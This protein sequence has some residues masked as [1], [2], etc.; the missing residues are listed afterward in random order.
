MSDP[1]EL[2]PVLL[3]LVL[4]V[5]L[6]MYV[7]LDGFDLGIGILFPCFRDASAR[8]QMMNS[9]APFWDGNET[10]L[11]LGGVTLWAAFPKAFAIIL[12]AMYLPVL[13]LL[14]ALIFRGVAFEFRWVAKG[15]QR[16]WD[17]A[18]AAGSTLAAFAQGVILGGLLQEI[19]VRDGQFAGGPFD[20]LSPF[21]LMCGLGLLNG[22]ALL[23][24]A[25]LMMKTDGALAARVRK[26]APALLA[27]LLGFIVLVSI[28]TP[29]QIPRVAQRWF[30]L[31]NL[32]FL[33]PV[34]LATALSA[35]LCWRAIRQD[36][37]VLAF[38]AAVGLFLLAMGALVLS[39]MPYVV[40]PA[41]TVWQAA[42]HPSSQLFY[43]VGASILL[44]LILAYTV[45]VFWLFRGKNKA[46]EGYHA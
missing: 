34:P 28:W 10:W 24:A 14:L 6:S 23:G 19:R 7:V 46:G 42:A 21:A 5:A 9:V 36:S 32:F 40:P 39:N 17:G 43:L 20:W 22:Y 4:G 18:F 26:M 16:I 30:S 11:V 38:T 31:P 45:M 8:D 33:V 37:G 35:W 13:V 44:P 1:G 2:L 25:W 12:P 3:A 27:G 15:H 29:L 41:L